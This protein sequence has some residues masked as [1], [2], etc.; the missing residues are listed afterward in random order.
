MLFVNRKKG[1]PVGYGGIWTS[2]KD[3]KIGV[4]A[5]GYGDGYPRDVP[6]GTPVYLNGRIVPIVGRV[7]M[8]YADG[9]FRRTNSQDKVGN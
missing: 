2:P 9:G 7:S 5:I 8:V 1:E 3:T 4:V 6:E